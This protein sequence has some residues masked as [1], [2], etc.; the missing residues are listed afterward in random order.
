MAVVRSWHKF[1][2]GRVWH[3]GQFRILP[4]TPEAYLTAAIFV[5]LPSLIR[6]LLGFAGTPLLPFT[7][8]Y[9]AVL[10]ATYIGGLGAGAFAALLGG[11]VAWAAFMPPHSL[12]P[13]RALDRSRAGS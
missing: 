3:N 7:V 1:L 12:T 10:F 13:W 9:P 11:L 6:W 4:G 5:A 8:F 2:P